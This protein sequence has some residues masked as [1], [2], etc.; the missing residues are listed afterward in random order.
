MGE[1]TRR[2][3]D[4]YHQNPAPPV[5]SERHEIVTALVDPEDE[6]EQARACPICDRITP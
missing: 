1:A 4:R 6:R 5:C 2:G 3:W